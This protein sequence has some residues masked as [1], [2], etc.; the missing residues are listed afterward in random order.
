MKRYIK[1]SLNLEE[2]VDLVVRTFGSLTPNPG[3]IYL[4]PDGVFINLY[5]R[6]DTHEDLCW[7]LEDNG[8]SLEY[9]DEEYFVREFQWIR[10]RSDPSMLIIE[11]P[12]ESPSSKQ[13]YALEDWL[14][15]CEDR[16]SGTGVKLYIGVCDSNSS[17]IECNFFVDYFAEDIIKICKRYYSSGKLY[18]NTSLNNIE[19][20]NGISVD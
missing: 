16:Y 13:W 19:N 17:D 1:S 9:K 15:Y 4:S 12:N 18:A 14:L 2:G 3:N 5:P 10:L 6:I 7:W 20:K 11:L 8:Y